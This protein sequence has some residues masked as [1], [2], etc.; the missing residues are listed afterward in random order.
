MLLIA[1]C[2]PADTSNRSIVAAVG[3]VKSTV[4]RPPFGGFAL[5]SANYHVQD[6]R[7]GFADWHPPVDRLDAVY[8]AKN[9]VSIWV[10]QVPASA[11]GKILD[12]TPTSPPGDATASKTLSYENGGEQV[13]SAY[14]GQHDIRQSALDVAVE[15]LR[16]G[17]D[18][19]GLKVDG[20]DKIDP[21]ATPQT[22]GVEV[23]V[24]LASP[25]L[26]VQLRYEPLAEGVDR[27]EFLN[28][29]ADSGFVDRGGVRYLV[30]A[31]TGDGSKIVSWIANGFLVSLRGPFETKL[32]LVLAASVKQVSIDEWQNIG[33]ALNDEQALIPAVR[34]TVF[35]GATYAFRAG[36]NRYAF[37]RGSDKDSECQSPINID[38][39]LAIFG[40]GSQRILAVESADKTTEVIV[41]DQQVQQSCGGFGVCWFFQPVGDSSKPI[42]VIVQTRGTTQDVDGSVSAV[43]NIAIDTYVVDSAHP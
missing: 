14:G 37:C 1:G 34:T 22:A 18:V 8:D 17:N 36:G 11:L 41:D 16:A 42:H 40:T 2:G 27:L 12:A 13:V 26:N 35:D 21:P 5:E 3:T 10:I 33:R 9:G 31:G 43:V 20:F 39:G 38:P 23:R 24:D 15:Q 28:L 29:G 19:G 30:T 32:G 7:T 4:E 25:E 6:I